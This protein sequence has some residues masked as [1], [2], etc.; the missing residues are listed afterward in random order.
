VTDREEGKGPLSTPAAP[1]IFITAALMACLLV[2]WPGAFASAGASLDAQESDLV[3]AVNVFRAARGLARLAVS[4][5]LTFA[6]KWMATDM[7]AT[8]ISRT[9]LVMG[10]PRSSA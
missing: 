5:T 9:P 2:A 7:A 6:S 8:T 10:A 1:R 3:T 4:D